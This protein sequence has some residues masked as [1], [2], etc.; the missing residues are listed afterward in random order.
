MLFQHIYMNLDARKE[1]G[2]KKTELASDLGPNN[3]VMTGVKLL[4]A[5]L[6]R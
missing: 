1:M 5:R 3:N 6:K 4:L 2:W